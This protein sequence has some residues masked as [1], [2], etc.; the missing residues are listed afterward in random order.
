MTTVLL[1]LAVGIGVTTLANICTTVYLHRGLSHRAITFSRP[2]HAAFKTLLW[3]STGIKVRE[4]VAVHRKHHA[5]TDTAED[6]HSPAI[7]GWFNVQMKNLVMYRRAAH[8]EANIDK[9]AKDLAP[10]AWDRLLFDRSWLGLLI[11]TAF[12]VVVFG[13][14]VGLLAAFV[15]VNYYLAASAAVNAIGHHFGRRPYD[16]SATNLQWLAFITA[17]EGFHNNHHAAPT[18]AKFAHRWYQIDPGWFVIKPLT[19]F[20][21][22]KVR[23]NEL[24]LAPSQAAKPTA[25]AA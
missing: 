9:Y 12:L 4:W 6:P 2:A 18:S 11:G 22:A 17:G 15:H 8:D 10:T 13:W 21:L 1:A 19:W 14:Q 7:S 25:N 3:L 16:N 23:L 20:R 5:H 24:R